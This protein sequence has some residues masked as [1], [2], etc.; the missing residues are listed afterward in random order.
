MYHNFFMLAE[1]QLYHV[2]KYPVAENFGSVIL[3]APLEKK[4]FLF[5]DEVVL[6]IAYATPDC[7]SSSRSAIAANTLVKTIYQLPPNRFEATLKDLVHYLPEDLLLFT[8]EGVKTKHYIHL[9]HIGSL[10]SF[11]YTP[12]GEPSI[13]RAA[14]NMVEGY[15]SKNDVSQKEALEWVLSTGILGDMYYVSQPKW[16]NEALTHHQDYIT[17]R[18]AKAK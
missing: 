14:I 17:K 6:A 8:N 18:T 7:N 1:E 2:H 12:L 3:P 16:Y 15:I 13:T 5:E 10:R 4:P 9:G 11:Q